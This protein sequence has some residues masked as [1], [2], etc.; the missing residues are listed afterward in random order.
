MFRDNS[1]VTNH[2]PEKNNRGKHKGETDMRTFIL[3]CIALWAILVLQVTARAD[4][5][6]RESLLTSATLSDR[7]I[8]P[9]ELQQ[10]IFE[11][12]SSDDMDL[13]P[14]TDASLEIKGEQN[15]S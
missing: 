4:N 5:M 6:N 15:E 12:L 11:I 13:E 9:N 8:E 1:K 7:S 3:T 10:M 14:S 2:K